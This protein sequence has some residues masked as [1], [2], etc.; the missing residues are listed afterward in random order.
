M[1]LKDLAQLKTTGELYYSTKKIFCIEG[2]GRGPSEPS[3]SSRLYLS[4]SHL[5]NQIF[6]ITKREKLLTDLIPR[7]LPARQLAE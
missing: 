2:V 4:H 7:D 3:L 6:A 5:C 1:A